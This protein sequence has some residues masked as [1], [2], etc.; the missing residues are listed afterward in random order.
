LR[1][2]E[3]LRAGAPMGPARWRAP[4]R[5]WRFATWASLSRK[6]RGCS[7][8]ML[9]ASSPCYW[10]KRRGSKARFGGSPKPSS[11]FARSGRRSPRAKR[12][13]LRRCRSGA[14]LLPSCASASRFPG[15]G[16]AS[17]SSSPRFSRS[18]TSLG[19]WGA[20]R[21]ASPSASPRPCPARLSSASIG[22]RRVARGRAGAARGR[23]FP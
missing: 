8:A 22:W 3:A 5:S 9:S 19:L 21:P 10:R 6:S 11:E 14:S 2:C 4:P 7:A 17:A 1:R 12:Q 18:T 20:A 16:V 15:L 13:P 23:Q